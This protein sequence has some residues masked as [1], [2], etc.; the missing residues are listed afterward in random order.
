MTLLLSLFACTDKQPADTS[1]TADTA[2]VVPGK[3][4]A[5]DSAFDGEDSVAYSGQTFRQLLIDDMKAHASG[6]TTRLNEG[7]VPAPGDATA[8]LMFYLAFDSSMGGP[9]TH[10]K[11]DLT[12]A[13]TYDDI[14]S[15]KD[16]LGKLAGNDTTGQHK[17]WSTA[18]AGWEGQSSPE[19]LVRTW[20]TA[21]DDQAVAW[22]AGDLPLGPDGAPVPHVGVTPDGLDLIQLLDKFTRGAVAFSQASD[23]YLDDDLEDH[24]LNSDHLVAKS[25]AN[26]TALEHGWDEGFGY[27]GA[28]RDYNDH[29]DEA[30]ADTPWFDTDGDGDID[31]LSEYSWGHSTNASKRDAGAVAATD[32]SLQAWTA[33][34]DG[35]ALLARTA[36]QGLSPDEMSELADYRDQ[37]LAAWEKAIAAT[38]VHYINGTLQDMSAMGTDAYDFG[39]H[40]KH[41]SEMKGF[42]L[43]PQFNP[44]SPI[45]DEDFVDLHDLLRDQPELDPEL[46]STYAA[47]LVEARTLLGTTYAFDAQNLG[48]EHGL[49]G[50]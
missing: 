7:W 19:G 8:E 37:A 15:D 6:M 17:D 50:W 32:F 9:L 35:R 5:F 13:A 43:V 20:V 12:S 10:G 25:G 39:D 42:A 3:A 31:L 28:A 27:F 11:A 26:Y 22:S 49:G 1:D 34:F 33:F 29:S 30:L 44:H 46:A 38:V 14:S 36:G 47:D 40:A 2:E 41:W 18:L 45:S 23:D 24:G 16:L 48:D 4:Y 21:L